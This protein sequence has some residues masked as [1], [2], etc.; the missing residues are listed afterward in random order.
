[1]TTMLLPKYSIKGEKTLA[2]KIIVDWISEDF[3]FRISHKKILSPVEVRN[4]VVQMI[5]EAA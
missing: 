2:T 4:E 5:A 1:M 3:Q